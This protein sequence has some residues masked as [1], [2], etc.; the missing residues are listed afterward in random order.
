MPVYRHPWGAA[1]S[2]RAWHAERRYLDRDDPVHSVREVH[3]DAVR[4]E[5]ARLAPRYD[6]RW[7]S[8]IQ[9]GVRETLRRLDTRPAD[10]VLDVGCGT[11]AML[12]ALAGSAH[13]VR[14]A[15]IDP[16]PEMLAVAQGKLPPAV[17]LRVAWAEEIPYGDATFDAVVC[18]S[19]FHYLRKPMAAL[20]EM[21]RVLA[22]G[23]R[24]VITDWCDDYLACRICDYWLRL[25][26]SAYYRAYGEHECGA[27]LE[28]TGIGPVRT[29]RYKISWLW[30]LM[31]AVVEKRAA[32]SAQRPPQ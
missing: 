26:S 8:Y 6:R 25:F 22:P 13:R 21:G 28:A 5:Y 17:E 16:S 12:A 7:S 19:V 15:G 10:R 1:R 30:G 3:G 20:G 24:L 4:R 27:L 31:T 2:C 32:R 14:L 11:G 9:A 29:D 23:G 18:C